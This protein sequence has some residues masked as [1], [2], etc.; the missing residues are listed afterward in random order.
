M[1]PLGWRQDRKYPLILSIHGGPHGMYGWAFIRFP[2]LA[3]HGY[4]VL[5]LNPRGSNATGKI[6]DGT[7]TKGWWRLPGLNGRR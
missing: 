2:G 6:S 3:A 5:Y 7:L 4:A 1:K